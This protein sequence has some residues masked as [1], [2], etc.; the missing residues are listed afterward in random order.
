VGGHH[1]QESRS[2]ATA[3]IKLGDKA[4]IG[5]RLGHQC[6]M[7]EAPKKAVDGKTHPPGGT[8]LFASGGGDAVIADIRVSSCSTEQG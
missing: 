3:G 5:R 8:V 7:G 4:Q 1:A 6:G 2:G